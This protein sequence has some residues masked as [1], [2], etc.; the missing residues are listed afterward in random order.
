MSDQS[1]IDESRR[2]QKEGTE[3]LLFVKDGDSAAAMEKAAK[4]IDVEYLTS[5]NIHCPLEPMNALAL[6]KDGMWH[7]YTGNQ[8]FTRTTI[9]GSVWPVPI[10]KISRSISTSSAAA[11]DA[12][13]NRTW[14]YRRSPRPKPSASR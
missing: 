2:L 8:F 4:V 7:I 12:A 10:R 14:W 11:S 1:I 13:W 5:I 3:G 6:E 9:I